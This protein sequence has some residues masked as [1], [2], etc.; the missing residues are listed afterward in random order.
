[1]KKTLVVFV[2][3]RENCYLLVLSNVNVTVQ[4]EKAVGLF[5]LYSNSEEKCVLLS[6]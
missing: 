5:Y 6:F 4:E 3:L 1:M 2:S